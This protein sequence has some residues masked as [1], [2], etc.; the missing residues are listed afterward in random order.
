MPHN[1]YE[2]TLIEFDTCVMP[3]CGKKT[4]Y[5]KNTHID[6]RVGYI[7]GCGQLCVECFRK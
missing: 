5:T 4:Q 1:A 3:G 7:E 2:D 6:L